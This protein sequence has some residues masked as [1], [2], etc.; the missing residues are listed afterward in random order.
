MVIGAKRTI[1]WTECAYEFGLISSGVP[2][3]LDKSGAVFS[4]HSLF[5]PNREALFEFFARSKSCFS[6]RWNLDAFA[7]RRVTSSACLCLFRFEGS[8][9]AHFNFFSR[10]QSLGHSLEDSFVNTFYITF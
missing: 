10:R 2:S 1:Q 8:E 5:S 4:S 3:R 9:S 7:R 6:A